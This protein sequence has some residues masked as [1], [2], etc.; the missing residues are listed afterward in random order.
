MEL[1]PILTG[2]FVSVIGFL[3]LHWVG[4]PILDVQRLRREALGE[5]ERY[6][7][8]G[9][10]APEDIVLNSKDQLWRVSAE[11]RALS[12]TQPLIARWYCQFNRYALS[13]AARLIDGLAQLAGEHLADISIRKNNFQALKLALNATASLTQEEIHL[14]NEE[15]AK[16]R[17]A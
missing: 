14:L 3:L 17:N 12:D 15:L 6:G 13:E 4:K 1:I 8:I 2:L 10:G 7:F 9:S 16:A 11:L 5:S